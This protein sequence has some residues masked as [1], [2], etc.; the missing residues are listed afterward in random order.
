[1]KEKIKNVREILQKYEQEH[2]LSNFDNLDEEKKEELLEQILQINFEQMRKLYERI[3]ENIENLDVKIE[4]ISYVDK[5]N[6][7]K[8]KKEGYFEN[9]AKVLAEGKLAVVTMAGGQG[10]RLRT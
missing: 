5:T 1:M 4:P 2:L 7:E 10:T 8:N 9:G 3:G 6:I